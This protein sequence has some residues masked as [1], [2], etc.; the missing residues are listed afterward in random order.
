MASGKL[1]PSVYAGGRNQRAQPAVF[2]ISGENP[3]SVILL[4]L[5][6]QAELADLGKLFVLLLKRRETRSENP[7]FFSDMQ[8][9]A[10]M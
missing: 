2:T 10:A 4:V 7:L 5:A 8:T 9:A 3:P 1:K 6:F